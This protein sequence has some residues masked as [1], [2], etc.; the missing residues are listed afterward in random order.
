MTENKRH[1][2]LEGASNLRDIGGYETSD[3]RSVRWGTVYRSG[4]MYRFT[5]SAWRWMAEQGIRAVCDLRS[6]EERELAP[7]IWQGGEHTRHVG[8]AYDAELL[9]AHQKGDGQ[10]GMNEMHDSLYPVFPKLLA[11][12]LKAMFEALIKAHTPLV[13]HCSA[14]Q[15][16]TGLAIGLL[17]SALGVPR[18]T[19]LADY[20]LSTHCRSIENELDRDK[21]LAYSE[22]NTFARYYAKVL[23]KRGK[24]ALAPREL[25]NRNG[26][27]LLGDAFH[28]IEADWGSIPAYLEAVL[29]LRREQMEQLQEICL[30]TSPV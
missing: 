4:A 12:S 7:T 2:A 23:R 13:V 19:I 21:I 6:R 10:G 11:P 26:Q 15:D 14:G 1:I 5:A 3:G 29:S 25:V 16:R 9:F 17:L 30:T 24:A 28:A 22:G 20:H 27:S 8:I 18:D